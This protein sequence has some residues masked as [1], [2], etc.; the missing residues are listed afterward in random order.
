MVAA[1]VSM[2]GWSPVTS[3]SYQYIL[4]EFLVHMKKPA[5]LCVSTLHKCFGTVIGTATHRHLENSQ[6]L[7]LLHIA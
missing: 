7:Y 6:K 2:L 5:E 4:L 1:Y 3:P